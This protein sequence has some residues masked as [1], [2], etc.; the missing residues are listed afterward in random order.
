M[1]GSS[2][3]SSCY[4]AP[5]FLHTPLFQCLRSETPNRNL[6]Y[7]KSLLHKP[8]GGKR[9][10]TFRSKIRNHHQHHRAAHLR[11]RSERGL[12]EYLSWTMVIPQQ[13]NCPNDPELSERWVQPLIEI[14]CNRTRFLRR[15][16][17][18]SKSIWVADIAFLLKCCDM[19]PCH[20]R[21]HA[22]IAKYLLALIVV[23]IALARTSGVTPV[24]CPLMKGCHSIAFKCGMGVS[25][26]SPICSHDDFA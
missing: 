6:T 4:I 14:D 25:L 24:V 2:F 11:R 1:I 15:R 22:Q 21:P 9:L 17:S 12:L 10:H 19:N 8:D 16:M 18:S 26:S 3:P 23:K 13:T 20:R 5:P 7:W